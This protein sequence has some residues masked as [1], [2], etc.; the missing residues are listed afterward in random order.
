MS[1]KIQR[2]NYA[3][4]ATKFLREL[5]ADTAKNDSPARAA[6]IAKYD[7]V[8]RLRDQEQAAEAPSKI[9]GGF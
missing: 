3:S 8:N 9:W 7:R 5:E 1:N 2:T 4:D 6:E